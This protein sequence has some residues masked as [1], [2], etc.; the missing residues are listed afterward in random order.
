MFLPHLGW[1]SAGIAVCELALLLGTPRSP[2]SGAVETLA[3]WGIVKSTWSGNERLVKLDHT[4]YSYESLK[5][6]LLRINKDTGAEF[7]ALGFARG[8]IKDRKEMLRY[9]AGKKRK[10]AR[11]RE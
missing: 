11:K 1:Y 4:Y 3:S 8:R 5:H 10:T 2:T 6:L 7:K 9:W